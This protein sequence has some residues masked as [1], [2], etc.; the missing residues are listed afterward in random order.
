MERVM[1]ETEA[2]RKTTKAKPVTKAA[3][4]SGPGRVHVHNDV[5]SIGIGEFVIDQNDGE[6]NS[7]ERTWSFECDPEIAK[8]IINNSYFAAGNSGGVPL[9]QWELLEAEDIKN[10]SNVEVGRMAAALA[11]LAQERVTESN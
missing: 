2:P 3:P 4:R 11:Q 5:N 7:D 8:E 9:T 6:P 1:A 10:R